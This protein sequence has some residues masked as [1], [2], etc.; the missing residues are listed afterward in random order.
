MGRDGTRGKG[1]ARGLFV[2]LRKAQERIFAAAESRNASV[3]AQMPQ[4]DQ[5]NVGMCAKMLDGTH[6]ETDTAVRILI[7]VDFHLREERHSLWSESEADHSRKCGRAH[8]R[9]T[10]GRQG[11]SR[12]APKTGQD[13]GH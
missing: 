12:K 10:D 3:A 6:L 13:K 9:L 11:Y 4:G 7:K 8:M 1:A 2:S 5:P